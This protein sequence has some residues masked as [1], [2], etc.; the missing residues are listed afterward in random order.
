MRKG[1]AMEEAVMKPR[2]EEVLEE[3]AL[4]RRMIDRGDFEDLHEMVKFWRAVKS[5]GIFAGAVRRVVIGAAALLLALATVN[6][7]VR[8]GVKKWLGF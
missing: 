1:N 4:V 7:S 8:E 6:E 5:F 3:V 2:P